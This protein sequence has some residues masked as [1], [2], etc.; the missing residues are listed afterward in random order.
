MRIEDDG[1]AFDPVR[2]APEPDLSGDAA[3]RPIGGLGLHMVR[4]M[5]Q[6]MRYSRERDLNRLAVTFPD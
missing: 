3:E 5:T 2:D 6:S 1:H 4:T